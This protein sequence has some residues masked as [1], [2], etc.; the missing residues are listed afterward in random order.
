MDTA[1][2]TAHDVTLPGGLRLSFRRAGAGGRT[3]LLVHGLASNARLWD[4]VACRLAAA[5]HTAVAV[6]Q[7]GHG[8]SGR[9]VDGYDTTTCADDLAAVIDALGLER[10]IVAG[11]SWGGN[12]VLTLA[13]EYPESVGAVC[14]VDGGWLRPAQSFATFEECWRVLEPPHMESWRWDD[15][16]SRIRRSMAGWPD[17]AAGAMLANL[18]RTPDGGVR[19]HLDRA[20]HRSIVKSLYDG[21][22]RSLYPRI[23]APVLLCPA[24][25]E[26]PLPGEDERDAQTRGAVREALALLPRGNVRWFPGANH[27]LHAQHPDA[28]AAALLALA[29]EAS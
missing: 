28:L 23:A 11:Q 20:H 18:E 10:P 15:I 29:E 7:R 4:G 8:A 5:G 24:V 12:V 14:C 19:P 17:D 22:P 2:I 9:P 26:D 21:D 27:D 6:D 25:S 16:E 3:F 1:A 13:A